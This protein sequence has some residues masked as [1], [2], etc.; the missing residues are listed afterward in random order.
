MAP[1]CHPGLRLAFV[2]ELAAVDGAVAEFFFDAEELVV[3]GH[4]VGAGGGAGFDLAAVG[5]DGDVGDG[6][7]FG[8]AAAMGEDG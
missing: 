7:V 4:A 6:G 2:P 1:D 8:F 5:G 3:F